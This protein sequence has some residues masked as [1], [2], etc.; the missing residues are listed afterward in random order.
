M[1]PP[2]DLLG[3]GPDHGPSPRVSQP[4]RRLCDNP[5]P[6]RPCKGRAGEGLT[7][8]CDLAV[9]QLDPQTSVRRLV[10]ALPPYFCPTL[11]PLGRTFIGTFAIPV[12]G[13]G[14]SFPLDPRPRLTRQHL[15]GIQNKPVIAF[16]THKPGRPISPSGCLCAARDAPAAH[17]DGPDFRKR[18]RLDEPRRVLFLF[19]PLRRCF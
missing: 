4:R 1:W 14:G 6:Q 5:P 7:L 8:P 9:S 19:D 17:P 3:D 10:R 11:A 16:E 18:R 15:R 13:G 2:G 12:R